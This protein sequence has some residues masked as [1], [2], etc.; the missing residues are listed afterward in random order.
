MTPARGIV[1]RAHEV[2]GI[3]AGTQTQLRRVV[4]HLPSNGGGLVS[5]TYKYALIGDHCIDE[6][7]RTHYGSMFV[8]DNGSDVF[9]ASPFGRP[10]DRLWGKE[11]WVPGYFHNPDEIGGPRV[12][13]I[14]RADM[15]EES[16]TAPSYEL[17]E[18]WSA[19]YS[20]D[21]DR[22]PRSRPS[23]H[24]P[25]WTSRLTLEIESVRI[26]RVQSISEEDCEAEGVQPRHLYH[27]DED[28]RDRDPCN[29]GFDMW[30]WRDGF[31]ELWDSINGKTATWAS[32][33]WVFAIAFRRVDGAK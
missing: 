33:P 15:A 13:V 9:V 19:L 14:Y 18:E 28:E 21:G 22:A 11:A 17:A 8:A 7:L 31:R 1:L 16:V 23:T 30:M 3:L 2:R 6:T 12:S 32:N 29:Q 20:E 10:G 26:E 27:N 25:R 4:K 24:M 5:T